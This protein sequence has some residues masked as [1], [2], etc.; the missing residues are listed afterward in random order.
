MTRTTTGRT[1]CTLLIGIHTGTHQCVLFPLRGCAT[2]ISFPCMS[3]NHIIC[4]WRKK[5]EYVLRELLSTSL[6]LSSRRKY[7]LKHPTNDREIG[8]FEGTSWVPG[9]RLGVIRAHMHMS[10]NGRLRASRR[11]T[12][13]LTYIPQRRCADLLD[14]HRG[15]RRVSVLAFCTR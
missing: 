8:N 10:M 3:P 7:M 12:L 11:R 9:T 14:E 6:L 5:L 13:T 4:T 15:T 2:R 1:P